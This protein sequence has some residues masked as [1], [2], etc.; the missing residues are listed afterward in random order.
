MIASVAGAPARADLRAKIRLLLNT[1][2]SGPVSFFLLAED[3]GFLRHAGIEMALSQGG[4]AAVVVPQ[5]GPARYDAGYGD[6]CALI[7]RIARGNPRTR[8]R[9]PIYTTFNSD[10]I[11]DRG[12]GRRSDSVAEGFEGRTIIGHSRRCG[13]VDIRPVGRSGR[14]RCRQGQVVQA[15]RSGMG[16][17]VAEMLSGPVHGVFG[18]VNTII[19]SVAPLG[20]DARS[21]SASST[22][23]TI[24]RKCTATRCSSRATS[25]GARSHG[26]HR[27]CAP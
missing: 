9:S 19:A 27:S 13:A 20:I 4:G 25:T 15:R 2:F 7:E 22:T 16:S 26:W 10:S 6:M 18:F 1:S 14:H 17:Q 23:P 12:C 5:V 3:R 11:H 8:G 21:D 24:C